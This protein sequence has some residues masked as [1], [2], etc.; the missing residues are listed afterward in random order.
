MR[1]SEILRY[2]FFFG[3]AYVQGSF[4]VDTLAIYGFEKTPDESNR[5]APCEIS[6][7]PCSPR[8]SV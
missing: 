4:G 1:P 7:A 8:E 6:E 2:F 5:E 3:Q